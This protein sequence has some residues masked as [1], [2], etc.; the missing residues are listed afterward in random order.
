MAGPPFLLKPTVH[1]LQDLH[2]CLAQR[3]AGE[4]GFDFAIANRHLPAG[5][6]TPDN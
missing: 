4:R 6:I 3:E 5:N 2:P 1:F